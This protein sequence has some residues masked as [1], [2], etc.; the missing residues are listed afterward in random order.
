MKQFNRTQLSPDSLITPRDPTRQSR[1]V[2]SGSAAAVWIA[3]YH[4][5]RRAILT[6]ARKLTE[7]SFIY[8]TKPGN[9]TSWKYVARPM[10]REP[11]R[12]RPHIGAN[13]VSWK[14]GWKIKKQK[15]AKKGSFLCLCYILRA[16]GAGRC[17]ERR[18]A[19]HIFIQIYFRMHHFV[20]KFSKKSPQAERGHWPPNQ[21]P[22]DV[23]DPARPPCLLCRFFGAEN[24]RVKLLRQRECSNGLRSGLGKSCSEQNK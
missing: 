12:G 6:R 11:A 20:V 2:S 9:I 15:H 8:S 17:R 1:F 16:I 13:G 5:M 19:D 3:H 18:Y 4:M 24:A 23:Y 7:G 14:N 10:Q 21:N 22:A